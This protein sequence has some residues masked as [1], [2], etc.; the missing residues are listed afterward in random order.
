MTYGHLMD[1]VRPLNEQ[2]V[3]RP[4]ALAKVHEVLGILS[5]A[6]AESAW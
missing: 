5:E 2:G 3:T 4:S 6:V 1:V